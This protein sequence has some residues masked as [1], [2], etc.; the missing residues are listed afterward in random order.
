MKIQKKITAIFTAICLMSC[1]VFSV[2]ASSENEFLLKIDEVTGYYE[3]LPT[4]VVS[5][6]G[7]EWLI[8]GQARNGSLQ[9]AVLEG[10][11]E[12]ACNY[13]KT[14]GSSKLHNRKSTDNTR[15]IVALSSIGKDVTN[16]SGYNLLEPLADFDY[17]KYQGIN[18][19]VWALIALDTKGYEIPIDKNVTVQTTRDNLIRYILNEQLDDGGW[20]LSA[21]KADPDITAMAVQA[22]APYYSKIEDVKNAVNKALVCISDMQADNGGFS[23]WGTVNSESCAQVIVALTA[24]GINPATD[25]RFIKNNNS[26]LD[27]ILNFS[28][29]N[30]FSH[31]LN[32]EYNQ[33]A[34]EQAYYALVAYKRLINGQTS[35]YD[36]SEKVKKL[37]DLNYDGVFDIS[38]VTL[39]QQYLVE[40]V[41]FDNTQI[42]LADF[43]NDNVVN[44]LD[45]TLMQQYLVG[46][47]NYEW[48]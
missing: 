46:L 34:T 35:L 8:I 10:Y 42:L 13:V 33:M 38:D 28:V 2:N 39:L 30:G 1:F 7:G 15:M 40:M 20:D 24:L 27:A 36:M 37:P 21:K 9:D 44:V 32:S 26:V 18:G 6:I 4:P 3:T 14:K 29:E 43:N 48:C 5:S 11:Y 22:L 16:V 19:P 12:N 41:K 45:V 17:I 47:Y 23:S 31:T 25:S